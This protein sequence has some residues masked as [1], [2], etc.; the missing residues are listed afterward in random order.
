M[1]YKLKREKKG[2][3]MMDR[4]LFLLF[5]CFSIIVGVLL[6]TSCEI[7]S[8]YTKELVFELQ[9]DGYHVVDLGDTESVDIIIPEKYKGEPVVAIDQGAFGGSKIN[10]IFIPNTVKNIGKRA[11]S[12]CELTM[13]TIE[14]DKLWV[15]YDAFFGCVNLKKVNFNGNI[16]EWC[17]F[18]FE[19]EEASPFNTGAEFYLNDALVENL[20]IP[21]DAYYI[22]QF[23]FAKIPNIKTVKFEDGS[24][25][26]EIRSRAFQ[27]CPSLQ[28]IEMP[29]AMKIIGSMSFSGCS[30][31]E[32]ISFDLVSSLLRFEEYA[33]VGCN[34]LHDV[35]ITG[36]CE[37]WLDIEKKFEYSS[38]LSNGADLYFDGQL[39][40]HLTI[41]SESL[42]KGALRGCTSIKTIE[43]AEG[44]KTIG[45]YALS[46]CVNLEKVTISATAKNIEYG[47]FDWC[48]SLSEVH[49]NGTLKD[50]MLISFEDLSA[51]PLFNHSDLYIGNELLKNLVI[52]EGITDIYMHTFAGCTSIET[53]NVPGHVFSIKQAAFFEC[54]NITTVV[55][56]EGVRYIRTQ[57]F[58]GCESVEYVRLPSSLE[59]FGYESD[60]FNGSMKFI[61]FEYNDTVEKWESI[62]RQRPLGYLVN[63]Y[64]IICT[65]G[66]IT[67]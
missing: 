47:A 60:I 33:F 42:P 36:N 51:N 22:G 6:F 5:V 31:L 52:P 49:F 65:N 59:S 11:F 7:D 64:I 8:Q 29:Q 34:N 58:F 41:T 48:D 40:E 44:V 56:D 13:L 45:T 9:E 14:S 50:W 19:N 43:F 62:A 18:Y 35:Y 20:V 25:C 12:G 10:S 54:P 55:I 1:F 21:K 57:A 53:V 4:K 17:E 66:S 63:G 61:T 28:V 32:S 23:A 38:P 27:G 30:A 46:D 67:E 16:A 37:K 15:D 24:N 3:L 2:E 26:Y 39:V